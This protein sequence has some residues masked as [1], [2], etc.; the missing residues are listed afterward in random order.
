MST[1]SHRR[2]TTKTDRLRRF[3]VRTVS[4]PLGFALC[5]SVALPWFHLPVLG[6]SVPAPAWNG[7]GLA[8]FILGGLHILRSLNLTA[9]AW[10]IRP[11]LP[12]AIYRWWHSEEVFRLWGKATLA[13]LQMR[14][15]PLNLALS[16][17]GGKEMELFEA[18]LW[19]ELAPGWGWTLAGVSLVLALVL[20]LL[21][22][23]SRTRCPDCKVKVQPEDPF[24]NGCGH[25]FPDVPGC[26]GCG[27]TPH[28]GDKHC[29]SCG[30]E[31][32][33]SL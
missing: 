29:R 9:V 1:S 27:R 22:W 15:A 18:P 11:I 14:L 26:T 16:S 32:S 10:L 25:R 7:L 6:W 24:C 5:A 12:W 13:P 4:L 28:H 17:L 21:D 19:R 8:L 20:T 31:L 2:P 30:R 3:A 33:V 23:P